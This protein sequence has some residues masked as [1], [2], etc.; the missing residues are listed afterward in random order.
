M[1]RII[2]HLSQQDPIAQLG[3]GRKG[4]FPLK[5]KTNPSSDKTILQILKSETKPYW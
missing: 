2:N 1:T 3:A 4:L 5:M